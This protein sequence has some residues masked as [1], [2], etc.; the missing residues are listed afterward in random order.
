MLYVEQALTQRS[1]GDSASDSFGTRRMLF[2]SDHQ[3]CMLNMR[4]DTDTTI[5]RRFC[6]R[7]FGTRRTLFESDHQCCM[8]NMKSDTDTTI[9]RRLLWNPKNTVRERSSVLYVVWGV[10]LTQRSPGDSFGTQERSSRAIISV[11]RCMGS[12]TKTPGDS[13]GTQ[14]TLFESTHHSL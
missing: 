5:P 4:S 13:F 14:R 9:P 1:P 8:L 3:C 10:T 7:L 2:E 6:Q 11:V 12:N